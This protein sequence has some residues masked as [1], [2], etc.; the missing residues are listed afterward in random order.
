M[1]HKGSGGKSSNGNFRIIMYFLYFRAINK[2]NFYNYFFRKLP[3][4]GKLEVAWAS[5]PSF[6]LRLQ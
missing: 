1:V 3:N 2:N 4:T 6:G 5:D